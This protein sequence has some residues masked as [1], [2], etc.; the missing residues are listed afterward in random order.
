MMSRPISRK[1]R[2]ICDRCKRHWAVDRPSAGRPNI[3]CPTCPAGK[4]K[5]YLRV[6]ES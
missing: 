6:M 3:S 2:V 4:S 5:K 1:L